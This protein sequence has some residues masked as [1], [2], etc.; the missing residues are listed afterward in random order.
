[1]QKLFYYDKEKYENILDS[2]NKIWIF[3]NDFLFYLVLIFIGVLIFESIWDN[4][5]KYY[6]QI[7]YFDFSISIVFAIEY[8][9]R[10]FKARKKLSFIFSFI[11]IVDLLSFLPFFLGFFAQWDFLK[12]L[13]LFRIFRVLRILK[14][15]SLTNTFIKSLKEYQDEYKAIFILF[16]IILFIWSFFVYFAE[17]N[18]AWTSFVDI[19]H[20]LWWGLVT[21]STVWYGDMYPSTDLGKIF[22]SILVFIWPVIYGLASAVTVMVFAESIKSHE[23]ETWFRRWKTCKVCNKRNY[24]TANYC[25]RCGHKFF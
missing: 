21:M 20:T 16:I 10:L 17:K 24:K 12:I 4:E 6:M 14:K 13:R 15:V 23:F 2:D 22:A 7:Y 5:T 11:W 25:Q 19:P 3:L 1:M 9:Y 8:F 18:V